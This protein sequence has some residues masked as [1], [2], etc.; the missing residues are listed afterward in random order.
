M[1]DI[2]KHRGI[3][4]NIDGSHIQV[5]IVQTSACSACSVKGHCNAS[6]SKDKLIDVY[7]NHSAE[8]YIGQNV[9]VHGTTSMGMQAVLL[10]FGVP[11][12]VLFIALYA[13]LQITGDELTAALAGL[14]ALFPY[15]LIIYL[16]R[17]KLSRKFFFTIEPINN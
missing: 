11:F 2:I 13:T 10:A 1:A 5:R 9:M 3:V 14:L 12:L 17:G 4:E 16:C 6:E 7:E 15:Y 8:Y